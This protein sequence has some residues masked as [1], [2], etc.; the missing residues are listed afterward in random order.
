LTFYESIN[1][2]TLREMIA[3]AQ[4]DYRDVIF[5]AEYEDHAGANPLQVRDFNKPFG[6]HEIRRA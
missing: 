5:W 1:I 2:D 4:V 6:M 3:T